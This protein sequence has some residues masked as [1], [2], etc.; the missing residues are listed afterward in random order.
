M[1]MNNDIVWGEK[2]NTGKCVTNSITIANY[3]RR[4]PRGRWSFLGPASEK[5][6]YGTSSDKPDGDL[7]R[8]A[9]I[10]MLNLHSESG[11]PIFRASTSAVRGEIKKQRTW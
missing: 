11:H 6:W 2:A 1:S 8:T 9:E 4:F 3:A 10:K 5:K 7:D